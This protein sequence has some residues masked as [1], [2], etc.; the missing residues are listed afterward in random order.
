MEVVIENDNGVDD[1]SSGVLRGAD[2]EGAIC[3]QGVLPDHVLCSFDIRA[4]QALLGRVICFS[5]K[6]RAAA[7]S[8]KCNIH[9][10]IFTLR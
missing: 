8:I 10:S 7:H 6:A 1:N 2:G 3:R 4:C 5:I 9:A